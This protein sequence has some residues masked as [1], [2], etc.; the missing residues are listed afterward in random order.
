MKKTTL[1]AVTAAA[2][3]TFASA[4]ALDRSS[5]EV[6]GNVDQKVK[7][8]NAFNIGIGDGVTARQRIGAIGGGEVKIGGNVKQDVKVK[9][10]FNIGIGKK[11][12][13]CQDIG[14]SGDA[15]C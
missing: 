13:A 7:V 12:K 10:A 3:L 5:T 6:K 15:G 11:V 1:Y 2:L 9:N 8:D 14:V 4:H